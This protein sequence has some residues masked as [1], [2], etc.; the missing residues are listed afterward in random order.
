MIRIR[1]AYRFWARARGLLGKA[2]LAPGEALWLRPCKSVHTF[3]LGADLDLVFLDRQQRVVRCQFQVKP[4]R[5]V[6]C[7]QAHSVLELPADPQRA[8]QIRPAMQL[9]RVGYDTFQ[10]VA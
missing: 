3:A 4:W 6:G 10:F 5:V 8:E 7:W 2:P 9:Q 1:P